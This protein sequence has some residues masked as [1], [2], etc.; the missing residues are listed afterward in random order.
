VVFNFSEMICDDVKWTEM[1]QIY[2]YCQVSISA[3]LP[4]PSGSPH[5]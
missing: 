4:A 2:V 1:V 3:G 5:L